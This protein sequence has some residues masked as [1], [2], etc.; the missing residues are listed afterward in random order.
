MIR[1][2]ARRSVLVT[3]GGSGLG[4]AVARS[5]VGRGWRVAIAGRNLA[6]LEALASTLAGR[7][8]VHVLDVTDPDQLDSA[9]AA[10]GPDGLVCSAAVLGHGDV[11]DGLTPQGFMATLATNVGGT[12]N[13]CQ[14][15]MRAWRAAGV[16]GDIVTVSSLAGIRGLQRFAGFAA[17]AAS[18]HAVI[19]MTEALALD[20]RSSN[21]RVNAV[22]PGAMR[23]PMID[24]LP[25]DRAI[26][27]G[28]IVPTVEFLLDRSRSAPLNGSIIEI[29]CDEQ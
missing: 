12:F 14:S 25:I 6:R 3:G 11:F 29:H 16:H 20:A 9:I 5:L 18:K 8:E 7:V 21:I 17:Y 1:S 13:A 4:A 27:P 10:F 22:A 2:T 28:A 26:D 24:S 19:G 23:T 15:A